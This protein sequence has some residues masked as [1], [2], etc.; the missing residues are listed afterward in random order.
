MP[1]M[2][3]LA[4]M[5]VETSFRQNYDPKEYGKADRRT[6][7]HVNHLIHIFKWGY[8]KVIFNA[9]LLKQIV[10]LPLKLQTKY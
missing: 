2:T 5:A 9:R 8:E 7:K 1:N 10:D 3:N 6:D 4:I